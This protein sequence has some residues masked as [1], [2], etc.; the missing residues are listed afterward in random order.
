[1]NNILTIFK[2]EF[3]DYF[4][5]AIAYIA[6]CV[7]LIASNF[8]FFNNYFKTKVVSM[9][10]FFILLPWIFVCFI[11]AITMR[12]WAEE[13][14]F[15]TIELL[16]TYPVKAV[17]A[18][19]GKFLAAFALLAIILGLTITIPLSLMLTGKLEIGP[20]VGQYLGTLLLGASCLSIGCWISAMSRNQITA[21]ILTITI[22]VVF[23]MI[24]WNFI[25]TTIPDF[26]V[27][28]F[29]L[30]S[31]LSHFDSISRGVIDSRDL[32]FFLSV[33]G[34]FNYLTI[35]IIE[36]RHWR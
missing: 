12:L 8:L 28:M 7:F 4:N 32:I 30:L 22:I 14:S 17:E 25:L 11:P 33:I 18:V 19:L 27:P 3:K 6:I 36:G 15:G 16:L 34:F 10:F 1:M 13:K 26:L 23:H 5:S 24:G 31:F 35:I 29:K 21:F 2:K 20:V 9:R